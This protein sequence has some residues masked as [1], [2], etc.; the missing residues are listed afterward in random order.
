MQYQH[1]VI[2][3]G[4]GY[5]GQNLIEHLAQ[6]YRITVF[7]S[8]SDFNSKPNTSKISK[9]LSVAIYSADPQKA[10]QKLLS[11]H[12]HD[13]PFLMIYAAGNDHLSQ[14]K[15]WFDLGVSLEIPNIFY[16]SSAAVYGEALYLPQDEM[17]PLCPLNQYGQ[18]KIQGE[19]YL[20]LLQ[21]Q[22]LLHSAMSFRL[23]NLYGNILNDAIESQTAF[24]IV[25][26]LFKQAI[27]ENRPKITLSP[28]PTPD[29]SFIR[30]YLH[31]QDA[32]LAIEQAIKHLNEMPRYHHINLGSGIGTSLL[33]LTDKIEQL[34]KVSFDT[35]LTN[36][37]PLEASASIA[38]VKS[39]QVLLDWQPTI[40]LNSGLFNHYQRH[41][42]SNHD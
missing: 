15:E 40:D 20:R 31:I 19:Q 32:I 35:E 7:D 36:S 12:V 4:L 22:G 42:C 9:L 6:R 13:R 8:V 39:A 24:Q 23:F 28:H 21:N 29:K 3:G 5:V 41:Y 38:H 27:H 10:Y 33:E 34:C 18:E 14:V 17:H 11:D 30:D 2:V 37:P 16:L 26:F 1:I 25:D